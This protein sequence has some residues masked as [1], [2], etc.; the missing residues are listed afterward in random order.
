MLAVT[1]IGFL[2]SAGT[3]FGQSRGEANYDEQC[4]AKPASGT[5]AEQAA[6]RQR[7]IEEAKQAAKTDVPGAANQPGPSAVGSGGGTAAERKAARDARRVAGAQ[8][9]KEAKQ[10]PKKPTAP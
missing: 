6:Q 9:A 8:A 10:D 1:I 2:L 4:R 5:P 7:C 3:A